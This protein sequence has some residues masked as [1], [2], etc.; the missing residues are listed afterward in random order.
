MLSAETDNRGWRW[1][2]TLM[3]GSGDGDINYNKNLKKIINFLIIQ[4]Y[5][6]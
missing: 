4:S 6:S 1:R 5:Q 2:R 3:A